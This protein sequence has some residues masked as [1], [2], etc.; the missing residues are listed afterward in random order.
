MLLKLDWKPT[1]NSK[2]YRHLDWIKKRI[3]III[4]IITIVILLLIKLIMI[5]VIKMMYKI[6]EGDQNKK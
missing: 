2:T 1:V 5:I 6:N 3:I 4:I